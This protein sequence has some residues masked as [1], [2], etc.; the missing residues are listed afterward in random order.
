MTY[1]EYFECF[2]GI[3]NVIKEVIRNNTNPSCEILDAKA[4][5][6]I[7][8]SSA[9]TKD[10]SLL[11]S[12]VLNLNVNDYLSR[13]ILPPIQEGL[14][15]YDFVVPKKADIKKSSISYLCP[16]LFSSL[17]LDAFYDIL[18]NLYT[19]HF[20]IFVSSDLDLLTSAM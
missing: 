4:L 3:L 11:L 13:I 18:C 17:S 7:I 14:S 19:E 6:N 15:K 20:V 2:F 16:P 10:I 9:Y 12:S 8:N 1:C 5:T